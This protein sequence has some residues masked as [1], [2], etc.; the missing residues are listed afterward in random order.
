VAP[1]A[2]KS[3]DEAD[4]LAFRA[5]RLVCRRHAED[6]HFAAVFLPPAKRDAA[7]A[8]YAF[9]RMIREVVRSAGAG[10]GPR[11]AA[12]QLRHRPL[13]AV[14]ANPGPSGGCCTSHPLDQCL[15]LIRERMDDLY[16]RR[17]ELPAPQGRSPEHHV[18]HALSLSVARFQ[19]P[20]EYFLEFA[21]GCATELTVPRYATWGALERYCLRSGGSLAKL[22]ACVLGVTH[23]DAGVTAAKAGVAIRLTRILCDVKADVAAGTVYLPLEDLANF[24]YTERELAAGVMTDRFRDLMRFEVE[25]AR[26]L[27][28]EATDRLR[29]VAMGSRFAPAAV[30]AWYSG[31]LDDVE[32][33]RYD[34]FSRRPALT[35]G[36][37]L[38]RLPFAWRLAR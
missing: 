12:E 26:R 27:Y 37:R 25:R 9:C 13:A 5:A 32:R 30:L 6:L 21:E 3:A 22:A 28:R 20:P 36:D 1:R 10:G 31:L 19:I 34:V 4:S 14:A 23:S 24:R 29:W 35:G 33:Q 8:V 38:R 17:M 15:S 18:L 2:P 11:S 7:C 16:A